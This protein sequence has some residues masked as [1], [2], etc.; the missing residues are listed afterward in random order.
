MLTACSLLGLLAPVCVAIN[1]PP[2]PP[3]P[4]SVML[5]R[6]VLEMADAGWTRLPAVIEAVQLSL[7]RV[8]AAVPR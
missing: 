7:D 6:H 2:A 5:V 4:G 8:G 1:K 3:E